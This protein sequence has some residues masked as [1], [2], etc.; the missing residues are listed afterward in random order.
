MDRQILI[1]TLIVLGGFFILISLLARRRAPQSVSEF[2]VA[3]RSLRPSL[4]TSLL[5]S[6]AFSL[7]GM[8]YQ[9]YLGYKIGFWAL[10]PQAAWAISFLLL[11]RY[12]ERISESAG[13]H[14]FLG[15]VFSARTRTL[16]A[17]CSVIGLSLQVGWE[18]SVAKSAF[19]GLTTPPLSEIATHIV[20]GAIFAVCALYTLLGGLRSNSWTDLAQNFLKLSC[21]V[22][23]GILAYAALT[24]DQQPGRGNFLPT[25]SAMITELTFSGLIANLAFSLAWQFGEMST[26]QTAVAARDESEK[27]NTKSAL[28]WAAL[29]VFIAPG[30]LGTVVGIAMSGQVGL[31]SNSLLPSLLTTLGSN[32]VVLVILVIALVAAVMSFVDGV[33]LA[34]TY[35]AVTDLVFRR[36]VDKYN[37]LEEPTEERVAEPG[38]QR[39]LSSVLAV[40]RFMLLVAVILGTL[41]LDYLS[42]L[43]VS[44]FDQVYIVTVAQLSLVGPAV[45][46][47][48]GW[49]A[50]PGAGVQAILAGL[51]VGFGLVIIGVRFD[52]PDLGNLA[53][54]G[55]VAASLLMARLRTQRPTTPV[56]VPRA[57]PAAAS[58]ETAV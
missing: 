41:A 53:P 20:V 12:S 25:P 26:W 24:A 42:R 48:R 13:L 23:L 49:E 31:D 57:T 22:I 43:G 47:L 33:V 21:F 9:I 29:W 28:K 56:A 55:A 19:S 14:S 37:L 52:N 16:A 44:L 27:K 17:I 7:N 38:Y 18:Y 11:A 50:K 1:G 8:L 46:G 45:Q 58:P 30:I 34:I 15:K 40:S 4:V 6:G 39:A 32:P 54:V 3:S 51:L 10:L 5:L 36:K 2:F 35:T